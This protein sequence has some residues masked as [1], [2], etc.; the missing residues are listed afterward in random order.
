MISPGFHSF[1]TNLLISPSYL[2]YF[3]NNGLLFITFNE[4]ATLI[5]R[6]PLPFIITNNICGFF[7]Q[8]MPGVFLYT[9]LANIAVNVYNKFYNRYIIAFRNFFFNRI[10]QVAIFP[11]M[12]FPFLQICTCHY[13]NFFKYLMVTI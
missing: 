5:G 11:D 10:G 3:K 2:F 4:S 9:Y 1:S 7:S 8:S 12:S 13:F 6:S